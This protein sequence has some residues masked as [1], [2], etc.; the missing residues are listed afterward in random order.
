MARPARLED[1]PVREE[2]ARRGDPGGGGVV[3]RDRVDS[4]GEL[5]EARRRLRD[6]DDVAQA[7]GDVPEEGVHQ[8][9]LHGVTAH[10]GDFLEDFPRLFHRTGP[11]VEPLGGER[12]E[13][14]AS[15]LIERSF[16]PEEEASV[17]TSSRYFTKVEW[18][19]E[20]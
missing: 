6:I 10:D 4:A 11:E 1:P 5:V 16:S 14:A 7:V 2:L 19:T 8:S 9:P 3:R 18:K 17:R 13:P 20:E 12:T 15:E